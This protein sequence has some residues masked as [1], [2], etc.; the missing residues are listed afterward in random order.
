MKNYLAQVLKVEE[1]VEDFKSETV[2]FWFKEELKKVFVKGYFL[3]PRQRQCWN[4]L[5]EILKITEFFGIDCLDAN[6]SAM[7][8]WIDYLR[9][10]KDY[11]GEL[12]V[13]YSMTSRIKEVFQDAK[14]ELGKKISLLEIDEEKRLNEALNC[15]VQELNYSSIVMSISAIE[16]RLFSLM[17]LK[18]P[19]TKL[20]KLTL[21]GLIGEYLKNKKKYGN[22]I[23]RK[24]LPLLKYC[25]NYRIFSVHPKKEKINR[26]NATAVLCMTCS[27][28]FDK[29]LKAKLEKRVIIVYK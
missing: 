26:L 21:G 1:I 9:N 3:S 20:E 5:N 7:E 4:E 27:F 14:K 8:K 2:N 15:Y 28:L 24:H 17:I 22:I 18:Q 10:P 11:A 6:K 19:S 23:P 12:D 29:E 16:S 25:S 13:F